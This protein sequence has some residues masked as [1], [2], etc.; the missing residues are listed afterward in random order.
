LRS[1]GLVAPHHEEEWRAYASLTDPE[2]RRAFLRTLRAVVDVGGQT[3]TANDWLYLSSLLPTLIVWGQRDRIIPVGH[4]HDAHRAMPHSRLV[5]F[6]ESGHL[7]H[8][9]EP[10]RFVETLRDFLDHT[11]PVHVDG[12]EWRALLTAGPP[13]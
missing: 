8:H 11:E 9:D 2:A 3:V 6:E 10:Q 4:A 5:V 1:V 13:P 12:P 7:P